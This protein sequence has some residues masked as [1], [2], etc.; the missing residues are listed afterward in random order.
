MD[1]EDETAEIVEYVPGP[2]YDVAELPECSRGQFCFFC[3]FSETGDSDDRMGSLKDM[4]RS[5]AAERKSLPQIVNAVHRVYN[6]IIKGEID[7]EPDW[8][9]QSIRSHLLYSTEFTELFDHMIER[10][11][12]NIIVRQ[13]QTLVD[14]LTGEI[15]EEKRRAFIDSINTYQRLKAGSSGGGG[16]Q[17][18]RPKRNLRMIEAVE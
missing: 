11:L 9:K 10:V 18:G 2:A 13:N 3:E 8:S 17:V 16:G 7:G 5:M 12:Q 15:I 1:E 14:G 6:E 4:V